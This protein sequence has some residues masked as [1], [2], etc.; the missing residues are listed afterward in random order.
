MG[1]G[2]RDESIYGVGDILN[3]VYAEPM[4]YISKQ[5]LRKWVRTIVGQESDQ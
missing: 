1:M 4:D 5:Y 3:A 2:G